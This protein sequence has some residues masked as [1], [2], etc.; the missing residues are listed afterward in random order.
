V[1]EVLMVGRVAVPEGVPI[2]GLLSEPD[3]SLAG[4]TGVA[5]IFN[6][7]VPVMG[8]GSFLDSRTDG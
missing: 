1:L 5:Q 8:A 4:L 2:L 6:S 3:R 7:G